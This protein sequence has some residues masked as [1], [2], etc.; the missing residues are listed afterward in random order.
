MAALFKYLVSVAA[1]V[2]AVIR[3]RDFLGFCS[4]HTDAGDD[5]ARMED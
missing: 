1:I 5:D 3:G 2:S 4:G